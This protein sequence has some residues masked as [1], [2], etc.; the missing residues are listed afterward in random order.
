M[1]QATMAVWGALAVPAA[2]F[3]VIVTVPVL[4][5]GTAATT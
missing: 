3:R 5:L 1:N 2:L 4:G